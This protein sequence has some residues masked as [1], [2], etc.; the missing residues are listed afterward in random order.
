MI[1]CHFRP[2]LDVGREWKAR[3]RPP[4]SVPNALF[5]PPNS[6]FQSGGEE[7][8]LFAGKTNGWPLGVHVLSPRAPARRAAPRPGRPRLGW[9]GG[10]G[11]W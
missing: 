4:Q 2:Q 3:Q 10:A 11:S 1:L 6:G 5:P 9:E 7:Q 8:S